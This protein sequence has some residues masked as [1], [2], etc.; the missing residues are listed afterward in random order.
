VLA[1]ILVLTWY[2][3]NAIVFGSFTASSWGGMNLS[4]IVTLKIPGEA[5][6]AWI[7]EGIISELGRFPP[8]RSP[9]TYLEYFPD[10]P[11]TGVPLLDEIEYSTN[12]P[13]YHHL[14]YVEAS[15]QTMKDSL[16]MIAQAPGQY[17]RALI[18]SAYIYF[19]SASDYEHV[20]DIRQP[21]DALDTVWNRLFYGQWQKGETFSDLGSST[22]PE[23]V[24]WWLVVGFLIAI[25]GTPVYLWKNRASILFSPRLLLVL[26]MFWNIFFV[27]IASIMLDIGE[28]N[29]F[30]FAIDPLI[31]W[32]SIFFAAR[33]L[34]ALGKR[35]IKEPGV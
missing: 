34:P 30:R 28:N 7:K 11:V 15:R 16:H 33:L 4:K 23:H 24:A 3:K 27:S 32:L 10:T 20:F 6:R 26:F 8:F 35:V 19:H 1:L 22:L 14:V 2:G 17:A 25:L 9:D 13:N 21:I 5:R 12:F 18:Q 31:L 29:R